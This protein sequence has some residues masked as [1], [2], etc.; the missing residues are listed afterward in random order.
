MSSKI[1]YPWY[2]NI[3]V[4]EPLEQG[5]F[6]LNCQIIQPVFKAEKEN[7]TIDAEFMEYDVIVMSQSCDFDPVK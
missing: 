4:A 3:N 2:T 6:V 1:A 5:D 7:Q